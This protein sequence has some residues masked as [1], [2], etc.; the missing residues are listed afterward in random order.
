LPGPPKGPCTSIDNVA[1]ESFPLLVKDPAQRVR[2]ALRFSSKQ[3]ALIPAFSKENAQLI[4]LN[5]PKWPV[6]TK[7]DRVLIVDLRDSREGEG[8]FMALLLATLPQTV[9]AGTN[10][11]GVAEFIQPGY[12][13]LP[14]TH[15]PF[16]IALGTSDN[17]GDRRS[18]DGYGLDVDIVLSGEEDFSKENILAL[19]RHLAGK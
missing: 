16:R 3:Q 8:E 14:H 17:Y 18:F 2:R 11:Y 15:L 13:M 4:E 1:G 12:S 9:I 5:Q 6:P 10:T 7:E 19:A